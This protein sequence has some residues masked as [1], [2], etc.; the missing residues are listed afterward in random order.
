MPTNPKVARPTPSSPGVV[1]VK[2]GSGSGQDYADL[3]ALHSALPS[4]T[5]L[6]N[7]VRMIAE[8]YQDCTI[9]N[10]WSLGLPLAE[11]DEN[12][13][14][15]IRPVPG[16]AEGDL[17]P[18]TLDYGVD[19]LQMV[20]NNV[21][22]SVRRGVVFEGFR[23]LFQGTGSLGVGGPNP[24]GATPPTTYRA[25]FERCR[26]KLTGTAAHAVSMGEYNVSGTFL[27]NLVVR[28]A[29]TS[30]IEAFGSTHTIQSNDFIA[31][32]G[33]T[34]SMLTVTNAGT[35]VK[36]NAF[37]GVGA[38]PM[39]GASNNAAGNYTNMAMTTPMQGFTVATTP[40]FFMDATSN[41]V[42][43]S[44]S[45]LLGNASDAARST[46]DIRFANSG[47]DPDVGAYQK[48]AASPLPTGAVTGSPKPDGQQLR[49]QFTTTGKPTG[50]MASL[51]P[52]AVNPGSAINNTGALTFNNSTDTG[53]AVFS[54][55]GPG[56]YQGTITISNDGGP[57]LVTGF[58]AVSILEITGSP[59]AGATQGGEVPDPQPTGPLVIVSWAEFDTLAPP[60]LIEPPPPASPGAH[61]RMIPLNR[62]K[63]RSST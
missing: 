31:L 59:Q 34:G 56:N 39:N 49:V 5:L 9:G 47:V 29:G 16:Y 50:G 25:G 6:T 32:N 15:T 36:D 53:E 26:M 33:S 24:N 60:I 46:L 61:V 18:N 40:P 43:A 7:G 17:N 42:P 3:D 37:H 4:L 11:Q 30:D 35:V 23:I 28:T 52:A 62:F 19:G 48:V 27:R 51:S 12:H 2:V 58:L 41:F 55:I 57:A 8:C 22:S 54:D 10:S 44:G 1:V 14:L 21:A 63:I 20:V 38:V 45:P 13:Y